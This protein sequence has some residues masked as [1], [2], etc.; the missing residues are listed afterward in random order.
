M[1]KGFF[2]LN[3]LINLMHDYILHCVMGKCMIEKKCVVEQ[4][5]TMDGWNDKKQEERTRIPWSV[6]R[7]VPKFLRLSSFSVTP[8]FRKHRHLLEFTYKL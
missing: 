6:E 2:E 1:K 8:V 3:N 7:V 4:N 5:Y